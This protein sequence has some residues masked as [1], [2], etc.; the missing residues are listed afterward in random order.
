MDHSLFIYHALTHFMS[1]DS[2]Y[3]PWKHQETLGFMMISGGVE[4]DQWHEMG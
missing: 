3:T 1:L 4:R 2:F